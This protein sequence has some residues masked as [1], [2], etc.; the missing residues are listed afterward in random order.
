M[1][2]PMSVAPSRST[3]QGVRFDSD[4]RV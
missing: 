3:A 2:R 4:I 1:K